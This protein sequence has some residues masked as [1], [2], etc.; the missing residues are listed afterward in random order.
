MSQKPEKLRSRGRS[1]R[2]AAD[3]KDRRSCSLG[4]QLGSATAAQTIITRS[5]PRG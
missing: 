1:A 5:K 2:I 4:L 3:Q